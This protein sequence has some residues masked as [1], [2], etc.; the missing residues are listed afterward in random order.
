[1]AAIQTR[2]ERNLHKIALSLPINE[3]AMKELVRQLTPCKRMTLN[4]VF[5][6]WQANGPHVLEMIFEQ[7]TPQ[8]PTATPQPETPYEEGAAMPGGT[9]IAV[10][11]PETVTPTVKIYP[12]KYCGATESPKYGPFDTPLKVANHVRN[13]CPDKPET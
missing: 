6:L 7:P 12:C 3:N 5:M 10:I 1:M 9:P 4:N 2:T 11:K 13:E 8:A